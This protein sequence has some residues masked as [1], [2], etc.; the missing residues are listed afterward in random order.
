MTGAN[1]SIIITATALLSS[2]GSAQITDDPSIC[3]SLMSERQRQQTSKLTDPLYHALGPNG[4]ILRSVPDAN[5]ALNAM[6][7]DC[8]IVTARQLS[9]TQDA[10]RDVARAVVAACKQQSDD[11]AFTILGGEMGDMATGRRSSDTPSASDRVAPAV[12][13]AATRYVMEARS[14]R[15]T[16]HRGTGD[17]SPPPILAGLD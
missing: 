3:T 2:C 11:L 17:V 14:G 5:H 7:T 9:R 16:S 4:K 6:L 15:C 10:T 13:D 12:A 8:L 1:I